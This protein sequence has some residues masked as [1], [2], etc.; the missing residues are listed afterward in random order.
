MAKGHT[1]GKKVMYQ[2]AAEAARLLIEDAEA[3]RLSLEEASGP[4]ASRA[5]LNNLDRLVNWN[6]LLG[7]QDNDW[8]YP[9]PIV[10]NKQIMMG[11]LAGDRD[12]EH[13]INRGG[14]PHR[15]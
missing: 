10:R 2:M 4:T 14:Q 5:A 9:V 8:F 6:E 15:Q 13:E 1:I 3:Q 12:A 7:S 11:D